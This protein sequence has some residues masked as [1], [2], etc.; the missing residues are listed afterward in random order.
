MLLHDR[1]ARRTRDRAVASWGAVV[2]ALANE[3]A[4]FAAGGRGLGAPWIAGEARARRVALRSGST[5]GARGAPKLRQHSC[6]LRAPGASHRFVWG[7]GRVTPSC[8]GM[9]A[10]LAHA[11]DSL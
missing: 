3:K 7:A 2:E 11:V 8:I 10:V 5:R 6:L 4:P 9:V 1:V